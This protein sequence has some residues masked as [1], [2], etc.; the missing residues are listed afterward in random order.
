M[1]VV[2]VSGR[3]KKHKVFMYVLSTCA[4]CNLAKNFL[5]DK[6][7]EYEYVDVDLC[8]E[9]DEEKIRRDIQRRGGRPSYPVIIIDDKNLIIGFHKDKIMEALG[10]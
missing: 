2:K 6:G 10:I 5:K 1:K 4:W 9:E 3:N 8:N 7:V